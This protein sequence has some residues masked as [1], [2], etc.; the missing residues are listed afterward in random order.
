[1]RVINIRAKGEKKLVKNI[2]STR[3]R[4]L[5]KKRKM[6]KRVRKKGGERNDKG[7]KICDKA[8]EHYEKER[9]DR[10]ERKELR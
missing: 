1:M 3:R 8:K 6:R 9:R 7:E 5:K 4:A 2:C 10:G